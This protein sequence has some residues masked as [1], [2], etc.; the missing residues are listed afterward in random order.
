MQNSLSAPMTESTFLRLHLQSSPT[1]PINT[2]NNN[3]QST[4][5]TTTELTLCARPMTEK[6][7]TA[8]LMRARQTDLQVRWD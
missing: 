2:T 6:T 1:P 4:P 5:P 8:S 3:P 7:S